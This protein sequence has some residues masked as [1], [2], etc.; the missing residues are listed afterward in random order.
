MEMNLLSGHLKKTQDDCTINYL[1][2]Y[3]IIIKIVGQWLIQAKFKYSI[4]I[5]HGM[6]SDLDRMYYN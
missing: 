3:V 6:N 4:L 2:V 1:I 5:G